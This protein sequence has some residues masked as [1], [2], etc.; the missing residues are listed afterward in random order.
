MKARVDKIEK[1]YLVVKNRIIDGEN[2]QEIFS[3]L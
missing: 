2:E 3:Q 1:T